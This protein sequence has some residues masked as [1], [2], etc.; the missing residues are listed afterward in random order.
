ML[1]KRTL[2]AIVIISLCL[3]LVFAGGWIYTVGVAIILGIGAWEFTSLFMRGG[4][5]P[6]RTVLTL[7]TFLTAL[8]G[9]SEQ[10]LLHQTVFIFLIIS[11]TIFHIINFSKHRK[12]AGVDFAISLAGVAFIP[13][14][15]F[16]LIRLRFLPDGLFWIIQCILPAGLSDIG[17][18]FIGN[19]LG[20][21]KIAP[22]ISPNKT[23]EGYAGGVLTSA[24]S[25]YVAGIYLGMFQAGFSATKGFWI[26]LA[27]GIICP[28][29]DL[30]KSIFKR[31]FGVKNTGNLIP[32]HGGVLDRID[33]WLWAAIS[34]YL[35]IQYL[36][37]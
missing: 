37:L 1:V 31:Q 25:G 11:L 9:Q 5:A 10:I 29:G 17:A 13:F 16:F 14:M 27:V 22:E 32:G 6:A 24:L 34:S 21:H 26:G 19:L 35:I 28:L 23:I 4:Y 8:S 30:A 3:G 15:G 18:F 7:G 20:K 2:S 33:T 36:S 12:T